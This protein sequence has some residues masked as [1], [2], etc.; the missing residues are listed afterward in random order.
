MNN[1]LRWRKYPEEK[2]INE[3]PCICY[4]GTRGE[5]SFASHTDYYRDEWSMLWTPDGIDYTIKVKAFIPLSALPKI[6]G[7]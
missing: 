4:E 2:P 6:E 3:E 1:N 5:F 7:L